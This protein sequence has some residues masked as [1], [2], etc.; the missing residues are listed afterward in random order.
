MNSRRGTKAKEAVGAL[1][2]P[3]LWLFV[4]RLLNFYHQGHV[5]GVRRAKLGA[6]VRISP[7]ATFR[8]GERVAIGDRTHIG[9]GCSLWAGDSSGRITVG[10]DTTFGPGVYI[11]ASNYG[12]SLGTPVKD[13]EK[14][15]EDVVVGNGVWLGAN[16]IVLPG[17]TIGDGAV[18]GAGSV[19]TK[20]IADN[21]IA[22]GSPAR[23]VSVRQP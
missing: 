18:V 10:A 3:R 2:D 19:V 15:E 13:Q 21:C 11:T 17:V 6:G 5:L 12:L 22:V 4:V 14:R 16:V 23:V 20:S 8:N 7:T 9:E 1:R